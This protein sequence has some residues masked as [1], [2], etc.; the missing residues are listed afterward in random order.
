[1]IR[2]VWILYVKPK[3]GG[4]K[5][6]FESALSYANTIGLPNQQNED[7]RSKLLG[8]FVGEEIYYTGRIHTP[9]QKLAYIIFSGG[10]FSGT[11]SG[12]WT[13]P[14]NQA[15]LAPR[16]TKHDNPLSRQRHFPVFLPGC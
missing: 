8:I 6:I 16:P 14:S 13:R 2:P 12:V 10:K 1:M 9:I 11:S 7:T 15:S 5:K 3:S 4:L